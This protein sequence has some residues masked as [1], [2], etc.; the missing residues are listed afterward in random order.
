MHHPT[1]P[2]HPITRRDLFW[3]AAILLAAAVMRLGR[4]DVLHFKYDQA[5]LLYLAQGVA[6]GRA[7]PLLGQ[8]SSAELPNSPMAHY[9]LALP[10]AVF[11]NPPAVTL[12]IGA[13]NVVGVGLLWLLAHRYAHPRVAVIA[14][15]AYALNPYAVIY[16]R[17]I[18]IQNLHT[19][20]ILLGLLLFLHGYWEGRRPAQAAAIPVFLAGVQIHYAAWTLIPLA[21]GLV[22]RGRGRINRRALA[23]GLLLGGLVMVPFAVGLAQ[24]AGGDPASLIGA[25]GGEGPLRLRDKVFVRFLPLLTGLG[26]EGVAGEAAPDLLAVDPIPDAL[27]SLVGLF[28]LL[29]AVAVVVVRA[30]RHLAVPLL[31]WVALPVLA[32]WPDWTGVYGHYF[33]PGI[34]ALCLGAGLG[35]VWLADRL[36][37]LP[38]R[39]R[40]AGRAV[41]YGGL[42]MALLS[43]GAWYFGM[44][45]FVN[46]HYTPEGFSTPLRYSMQVAAALAPY[47]DVLILGGQSSYSGVQVWRSL[48]FETADSV[49]EVV[50]TAGGVAVLPADGPFAVLTAPRALPYPGGDLYQTDSPQVFPLRPG[51]EG[52]Y[53]IDVFPQ[54]PAWNGPPLIDLPP[55]RFANGIALTG[56]ALAEGR[57]Y[58]AWTLPSA[59]H[60]GRY[61]RWFAHF[62][63]AGGERVTQQD[64]DFWPDHYWRAGDRLITWID[65]DVPEA[66][67]TLRLGL[68]VIED[69]RFIQVDVLDEAGHPAAP[70]VDVPLE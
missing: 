16:S 57:L 49:R 7:F 62:L 26:I 64:V 19:P 37:R 4:P 24:Y 10:Y 65:A 18:W 35:A 40:L 25:V 32:F 31:L 45:D 36:H 70:W 61:L 52:E 5:E 23:L 56:Y 60:E 43:Q 42:G 34:P 46:T 41:V 3:L 14:G 44:L 68:Y 28:T 47:D 67:V 30:Y 20:L 66:T 33:V 50:T 12:G 69:E 17:T 22:W 15:F 48:L 29:G 58:V 11:H 2:T 6:A 27:W 8:M 13:W 55:V 51:G 38:A 1:F 54:A 59:T 9:L 21:L 39:L 63:D 53:V